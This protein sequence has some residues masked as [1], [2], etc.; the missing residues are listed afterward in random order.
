M[1]KLMRFLKPYQGQIALIVIL[2]L[3]QALLNLFVRSDW[4]VV[5]SFEPNAHFETALGGFDTK[6]GV[7][8]VVNPDL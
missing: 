2:G 4:D 5:F 8:T 1:Q 3:G 7:L 6:D